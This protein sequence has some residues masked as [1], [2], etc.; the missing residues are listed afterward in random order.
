LLDGVPFLV[1][2]GRLYELAENKLAIVIEKY[3][4]GSERRGVE[5]DEVA[6]LGRRSWRESVLSFKI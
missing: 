2:F 4:M 5:V 6:L 1:R 3:K